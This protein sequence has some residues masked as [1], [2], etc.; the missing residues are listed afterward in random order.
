M[1][2][3]VVLFL[4]MLYLQGCANSTFFSPSKSAELNPEIRWLNSQSGNDIAYLWLPTEHP[5]PQ[6]AVIHFHGNSGHMEE[7]QEKVDWLTQHGYDVMVFDYS[8][9]GHSSGTVSDEAAYLDALTVLD[10]IAKIKHSTT[11]PVYT[12]ATSTGGNIFLR[13]WADRPI[14]IDGVIIDSS[15]TSYID[16]AEHVVEQGV[17]GEL[18]SWVVY[19]IMRDDYAAN[20]VEDNLPIAPSLV[21]HCEQDV[22]VPIEFGEGIYDQLQGEKEF[23]RL[24][25]CKH[26]R[27]LTTQ[28]PKNQQRLVNW[29]QKTA[30]NLS[31]NGEEPSTVLASNQTASSQ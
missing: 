17:F 1:L 3:S 5:E 10:Y 13:A 4:A 7:T 6:G 31:P 28:H 29:L 2:R 22:V 15:F 12:V 16:T 11:L 30:P 19:V 27:A 21:L 14:D 25:G 20:Q 23:W 26:A 18:V 8:G 9:F 24:A